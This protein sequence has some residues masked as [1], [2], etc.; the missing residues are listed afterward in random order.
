MTQIGNREEDMAILSRNNKNGPISAPH[1]SSLSSS[2]V[3]S[4]TLLPLA[5]HVAPEQNPIF[6]WGMGQMQN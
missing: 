2:L 5:T 1:D 6:N 3:C 4:G